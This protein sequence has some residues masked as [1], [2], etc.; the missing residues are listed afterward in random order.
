[1]SV[2]ELD[3]YNT[4]PIET[5]ESQ[6]TTATNLPQSSSKTDSQ[7]WIIF[8]VLLGSLAII[9]IAWV[10]WYYVKKQKQ[11]NQLQT[12]HKFTTNNLSKNSKKRS[13]DNLLTESLPVY[14]SNL[15]Y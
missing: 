14:K 2:N 7:W 3:F 13:I 6:Y 8:V 9:F 15:N 12:S 5:D 4:T 11:S 1:M 10:I